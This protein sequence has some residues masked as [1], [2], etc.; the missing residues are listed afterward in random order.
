MF[1]GLL[2]FFD[3]L[4][5]DMRDPKMMP[6]GGQHAGASANL[7]DPVEEAR[8]QQEL[9]QGMMGLGQD[10]MG[11]ARGQAGAMPPM[12]Q[13]PV[14]QAPIDDPMQQL[15][16]NSPVQAPGGFLDNPAALAQ[17]WRFL[18]QRGGQ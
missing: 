9:R 11:L 1:D 7:P 13:P 4:G 6:G 10:M 16:R 2:K 18:G 3:G 14:A 17:I 12:P 15:L 5:I 8:R